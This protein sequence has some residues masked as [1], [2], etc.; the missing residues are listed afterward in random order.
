[1]C[2]LNLGG[3]C[4]LVTQ[5]CLTLCDPW[6]VARQ[7]P[8]SWDFSGKNTVLGCHFLS[9]GSSW[10]RDPTR[11]SCFGRFLTV[12]ATSGLNVGNRQTTGL[13]LRSHPCA[14]LFLC[15]S[16]PQHVA[17]IPKA[18]YGHNWCCGRSRHNDI[19][20][21]RGRKAGRLKGHCQ[22]GQPLKKIFPRIPT[23]LVSVY[24]L[25]SITRPSPVLT[26]AKKC[27]LPGHIPTLQTR[28]LLGRKR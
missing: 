2:Y 23:Q 11:V 8:L 12:W 6:T 14:R 19:P 5:S 21:S 16:L 4:V 1:M 9:R 24:I 20:Q 17:S 22:H 10:P 13:W 7:A 28:L 18:T 26:E 27:S 3:M 25:F 15:S